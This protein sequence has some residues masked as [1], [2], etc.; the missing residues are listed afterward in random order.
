[1]K[2]NK[3]WLFSLLALVVIAGGVFI[4]LNQNHSKTQT[5]TVETATVKTDTIEETLAL[6]GTLIPS[7]TQDLAGNGLV[8]DILVKVGDVV[9]KD[10]ELATYADGTKLIAGIDGTVTSL[11]LKKEQVDLSGQTGSA[12]ISLANLAPL[13]VQLS[14]SNSEAKTVS[15][16][17]SAT[18]TSGSSTYEGKVSEK[19]PVATTTQGLA[20]STASLKAELTFNDVP[21]DLYA[22]FPVDVE[23]HTQKK[24]NAVALPL[25][26]LVYSADNQ[27]EVFL[28]KDQTA[29]KVA[30]KIGIQSDALIEITS[31][32]QAGDQVILSPSDAIKDGVK[33]T[34]KSGESH[35]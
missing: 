16:G 35:D 6:T 18:I 26:A 31:G 29:K 15:L 19:D 25:E 23:I 21:K 4:Y 9:K 14:L 8:T 32:I 28:V 13:K 27:P 1:M 2:K 5:V 17:Q 12:A 24:E 10:Q 33:I 34:E 20:A 3:K 30:V 7:E 11:S 22:G